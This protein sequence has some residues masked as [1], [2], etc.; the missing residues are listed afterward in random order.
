[1]SF[2]KKVQIVKVTVFSTVSAVLI[3]AL[4]IIKLMTRG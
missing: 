2:G 3:T 1:M 4:R